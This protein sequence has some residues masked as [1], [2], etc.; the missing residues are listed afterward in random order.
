MHIVLVETTSVRGFDM[1]AEMADSGIEV[2]FVTGNLDAYR[3]KPGFELSSRAARIV[4]VDSPGA[5]RLA[6]RLRGRLGPRRPD[7]VIGRDEV[8][9]FAVAELARD[10]GL[11]HESVA[12]ARVLSDKGAVRARLT[13]H[14]VGSLRWRVAT[15]EAEGRA[16]VEEIGLPV[17]VKPTAGG[18][19]VGVTVAWTREQ[20]AHALSRLLSG[21]AGRDAAPPRALVE[22]YAVGRHVSAELLVQGERVVLLGFAERLAAPPGQA[23]ELGGHFPARLDQEGAARAF[24]LDTVRALGLRACAVHAELLLTPAGPELIEVNGRVAGHVVTQQMSLALGRSLTRDLVDLAVGRAVEE[25][26][27]PETVVALHQL[28]SPVPAVVRGVKPAEVLGP[29]VIESRLAVATGDRVRALRTNHDRFGYVLARGAT[30]AAAARTAAAAAERLLASLELEPETA[31]RDAAAPDD[32]PGGE[33]LLLLLGAQDPVER[34]LTGVGA[35]TSR[36]SVVWTSGPDGEAGARE[37]WARHCLGQWHRATGAA[38]V[39]AA[40]RL[41]HAVQPVRG[42]LTFSPASFARQLRSGGEDLSEAQAVPAVS[43]HTVVVTARRGEVRSLAVLDEEAGTRLCPSALDGER[44]ARLAERA[45][46]AVRAA[47]AEGVVRCF[48]PSD[49]PRAAAPRLLPGLDTATVDLYDAVYTRGLAAATAEAALGRAPRGRARPVVAV[50]RELPLP[51]GPLRVVEA[52]DA[53]ELNA[54]P[55]VFRAQVFAGAGDVVDGFGPEVWLRCTAVAADRAGARAAAGRLADS[56]VL[57]TTPQDRTHVL[58]L[59]RLGA[60]VWTLPDGLSPVLPADRFRLSVLTSGEVARGPA[61]LAVRTD[62][63]DDFAVERLARAVHAAHPVHRVAALSERLLEPAARLRRALGTPGEGPQEVRRFVDKAVMKRLAHRAG[64]RHAAGLLAQSADD[65]T[66]AFRRHGRVVVKPRAASGSQ[67]VAV[68]SARQD[69][70][71]WLREEFVP[72]AYLC[73]EFV[74]APMCHIDAVVHGGE[75]VWHVSAYVRDTM[76]LRRGRP[77]SS[78]TVADPVVRAA[79]G[80]LLGRV[81]DA[82]RLRSG[83]LH[84]EAFLTEGE[85]TFCEVAARPGGGGVVDAFRAT[86]G[87]DLRHA[88][89]LADAGE[90]PLT[91]RREPVGPYAGW[92]VHYCGG[93]RLLEYDDASVAPLAYTRTVRARVGD[94][95]PASTFSGTGVSTHVFVHEAPGEV[96]ALVDRAEREVRIVTGPADGEA[97]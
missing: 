29:D 86:E 72:G 38:A 21:P 34:L 41:V 43:G 35:V 39:R 3:G 5:G 48:F 77:L 33:H 66:A 36:V 56:V 37:L 70:E 63:Y 94:L 25:A 18:W 55:E 1:V 44:V 61:D 69:V 83:V 31:T 68:L 24:V 30:G 11:P 14:G 42:V 50:Q 88:K 52:T 92:T 49:A 28:H 19:S 82:W 67:G 62:V 91:G 20:A 89:I 54:R 58:L 10:L 2:S 64:I 13:E 12:A 45:V 7:G 47:R 95:V 71:R 51:G 78:A 97:R 4:E 65:V 74:D 96:S 76:A 22:E 73:E 23:A 75:P 40:A 26:A 85:L 60:D 9:P 84:L 27:P 46:E 57:R 16:A 81:V 6:E 87:V 80:R 53:A 32:S 90:N 15:T 79:A 17:V 93:G 59:D 8:Y